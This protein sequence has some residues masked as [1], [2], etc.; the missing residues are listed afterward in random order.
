RG[1]ATARDARHGGSEVRPGRRRGEDPGGGGVMS[2][3]PADLTAW[4]ARR[5]TLLRA[6]RRYIA[7]LEALAGPDD[8]IPAAAVDAVLRAEQAYAR[9]MVCHGEARRRA[10]QTELALDGGVA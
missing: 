1:P 4:Q 2:T 5:A 8:A 3:Q 10:A 9:R 6:Y 7:E